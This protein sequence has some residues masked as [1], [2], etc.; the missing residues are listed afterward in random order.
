MWGRPEEYGVHGSQYYIRTDHAGPHVAPGLRKRSAGLHTHHFERSTRRAHDAFRAHTF[1]LNVPRISDYVRILR[2]ELDCCTRHEG[3]G[4]AIEVRARG[5]DGCA[6][7]RYIESGVARIDRFVTC[8]GLLCMQQAYSA[9]GRVR[10]VDASL[11]FF[12]RPAPARGSGTL[13]RLARE[14][15]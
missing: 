13:A 4:A 3:A 11:V 14:A 6:R 10:Y 9:R 1:S 7:A 15:L 2:P 12:T 8:S 5:M